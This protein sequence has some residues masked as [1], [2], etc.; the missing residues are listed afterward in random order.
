LPT[1]TKPLVDRRDSFPMPIRGFRPNLLIICLLFSL[2]TSSER[3]AAAASAA[4][5]SP[6]PAGESQAQ[7]VSLGERIYQQG[8]LP[9]GKLVQAV[10]KGDIALD[11]RMVSCAGCHMRSGF[12]S[13]EGGIVT[14]ANTGGKLFQPSYYGREFTQAERRAL[15]EHYQ[16]AQRRPAYTEATLAA[17]IRNGVDPTGRALDPVMPRYRLDDGELAALISYLKTLSSVPSPG[18]TENALHFATVVTSEVPAED[19]AAEFATL[20]AFAADW[21]AWAPIHEA[22]AKYPEIAQ[23]ADLSYR[24]ISISRWQLTG[25]PA[26]WR[27]Q[28]EA[29]YLKDPVFALLGGISKGEWKPIHE[30]SEAHRVPCLLPI[31]DFPVLSGSD[32]YTVYFSKGLYQEGETAAASL[33]KA[34]ELTA[35]DTVLQ[36]YRSTDE[37]RALA[38]GFEAAWRALGRKPPVN[39]ILPAD[40]PLPQEI[41]QQLTEK[42]RP[43]VVLLWLG[44]EAVPVLESL[45]ESE[46]RPASVYLSSSLLKQDLWSISEQARE[47]TN[48]TYPY[49]LPQDEA[50]HAG[51]AK[52]W[53]RSKGVPV[54]DHRISSRMYSLMLLMNEVIP[55][56]RR[57]FYRDY[58]LDLV[59]R[60]TLHGYPDYERLS[61]GPGQRYISKGWYVVTLSRGPNP[62]MIKKSD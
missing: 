22:R 52:V 40:G 56:M 36:L 1:E 51:Y 21:N 16:T 20:E 4:V 15:S 48:I 44:K 3:P 46:I 26:T 60:S 27:S 35:K 6:A 49:Q 30:F 37:G 41:I 47:F 54:D 55:K 31:T 12:G 11:G 45:A 5:A 59:D 58:L 17:A 23:E 2:T 33:G 9:S 57:N 32:W 28:L 38:A 61:F 25:P 62:I 10:V 29:Y 34:P 7:A 19:S 42:Q 43:S 13:T 53:L 14:P 39:L 50:T 24:N 18:V 8:I